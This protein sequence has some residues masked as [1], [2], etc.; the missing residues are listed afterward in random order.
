MSRQTS[1]RRIDSAARIFFDFRPCTRGARNCCRSG[2]P[3]VPTSRRHGWA[4]QGY[5]WCRADNRVSARGPLV[6]R[7]RPSHDPRRADEDRHERGRSIEDFAPRADACRL[8]APRGR[9]VALRRDGDGPGRRRGARGLPARARRALPKTPPKA[10]LV[11]SAH[12]EEPVP[13]VTSAER[14]PIL[15]E[16]LRV[17]AD[18]VRDHLA[19]ARPAGARGARPGAARRGRLRRRQ[20]PPSGFD[21]GAFIPL[22]L[23]YPDADVP[24]VQLSLQ[25]RARPLEHLALGRALAPLRDEGVFIVGS[26][27]SYHNMRGF[28][29]PRSLAVSETFDG[30][31][32]EAATADP[33]ERDRRLA[34]WSGAP[35]A[36][37]AHPREEHLLP[38]MVA[39]GAAGADRGTVA[40]NGSFSDAVVRRSLRLTESDPKLRSYERAGRVRA[41]RVGGDRNPRRD[42][43]RVPRDGRRGDP[44]AASRLRAGRQSASGARDL[45]RGDAAARRSSGRDRVPQDRR[46][47]RLRARRLADRR[48]RRRRA[49][50]RVDRAPRSGATASPGASPLT[51]MLHGVRSSGARG[52]L[53]SRTQAFALVTA[54]LPERPPSAGGPPRSVGSPERFRACS[55]WAVRSWRCR[56]FGDSSVSGA[57][58][59]RR[60]RSRC[61]CL[62]S[63][64]PRYWSTPAKKA[65]CPGLSSR[66]WLG[67]LP[68]GPRLAPAL[69]DG[70]TNGSPRGFTDLSSRRSRS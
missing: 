38:L 20:Q 24:A 51:S 2:R 15:Y 28:G 18:V 42:P 56:S 59:P 45:A 23:T 3:P 35:A 17:P 27:M 4:V 19:G 5:D 14:P 57:S 40:W 13:T 58:K 60:A 1:A 10:L 62:L 66:Q 29:D 34:E 25:A 67:A 6:R 43:L 31:L 70:R 65:G 61:C 8:P 68:S 69:R 44:A 41:H 9:T 52:S 30:W 22:K 12:W 63:A 54:P 64:S 49:G 50:R 48:L 32:R 55:A 11:A 47:D 33:G 26:G 53:R 46:A 21:H 7:R 36:R 37:L 16:L 39:A